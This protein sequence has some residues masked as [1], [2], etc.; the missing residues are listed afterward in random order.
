MFDDL[1]KLIGGDSV[2][3]MNDH[4]GDFIMMLAIAKISGIKPKDLI[5]QVNKPKEVL[6]Y[7]K[8]MQIAMVESMTAELVKELKDDTKGK[9]KLNKLHNRGK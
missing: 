1:M 5:A 7:G 6:A 2:P 4:L 3:A 9:T 8:E